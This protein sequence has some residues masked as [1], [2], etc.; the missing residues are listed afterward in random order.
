MNVQFKKVLFAT[1]AAMIG[2]IVSVGAIGSTAS[3][4]EDRCPGTT[5]PLCRSVEK[6]VGAGSTRACTTDFFYFPSP[7]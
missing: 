6:C 7:E 5:Q 2:G 1:A 4:Q 3:A